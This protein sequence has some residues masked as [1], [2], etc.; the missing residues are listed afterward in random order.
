[1][2]RLALLSLCLT[3]C[4]AELAVGMSAKRVEPEDDAGR[5]ELDAGF[6][7]LDA[8]RP[9]LDARTPDKGDASDERYPQ[10]CPPG[11]CIVFAVPVDYCDDSGVPTCARASAE[12]ICA[13]LCL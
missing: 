11:E 6:S 10:I 1:M 7:E 8:R 13:I 3:G 9:P 12:D 2:K 4:M 5:Q